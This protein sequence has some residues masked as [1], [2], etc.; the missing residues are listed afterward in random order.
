MKCIEEWEKK[1]MDKTCPL[2][3]EPLPPGPGKLFDLGFAVYMKMNRAVDRSR[4]GVDKMTPWALSGDQQRP[5]QQGYSL[6]VC[7]TKHVEVVA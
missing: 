3:R 6:I 7:K 5:K 4:P 2:C 1:G